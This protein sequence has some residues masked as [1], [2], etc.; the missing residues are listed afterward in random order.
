MRVI[1]FFSGSGTFS[2]IAR[3]RGH[4]TLTI[5]LEEKQERLIQ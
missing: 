3:E 5:D 2:R 4:K 1:E